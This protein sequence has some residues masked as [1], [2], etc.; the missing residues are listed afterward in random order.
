MMKSQQHPGCGFTGI[1]TFELSVSGEGNFLF[2]SICLGG[3]FEGI[4]FQYSEIDLLFDN[5]V[6]DLC[7]CS[8]MCQCLEPCV[9][10]I[11]PRL[12][13]T[14]FNVCT[15]NIEKLGVAWV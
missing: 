15:C 14:L 9:P 1:S 6:I 11:V 3:T 2:G 7:M 4:N 5:A 10:S 8:Y 12:P 13:Y